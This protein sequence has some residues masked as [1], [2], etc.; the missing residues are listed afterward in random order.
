[1]TEEFVRVVYKMRE[2]QKQYFLYRNHCRL[3]AAKIL[4]RKVDKALEEF[5]E[6]EGEAETMQPDLGL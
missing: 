6:A 5:A 2:A 3:S 4:E 1:M